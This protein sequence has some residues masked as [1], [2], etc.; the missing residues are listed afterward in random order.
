MTD[1]S[2]H[3]L[4]KQAFEVCQAI[5]QCGAS[6]ELTRAVG[7]ASDLMRALDAHL[8]N[9]DQKEPIDSQI[10]ATEGFSTCMAIDPLESAIQS[11]VT[12]ISDENSRLREAGIHKGQSGR[13][14]L[15]R[16][17]SHLDDLLA[18]QMDKLGR[19]QVV[20]VSQIGDIAFAQMRNERRTSC[21]NL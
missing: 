18:M 16:L 13:E 19:E 1:I 10:I 12:L 3:P 9:Y 8:K 15:E 5:E 17:G 2:R 11:A 21:T 6:P 20:E 7:R 4:L 14:L